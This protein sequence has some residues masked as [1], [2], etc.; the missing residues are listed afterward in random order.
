MSKK[1]LE[2]VYLH[3]WYYYPGSRLRR[4][5]FGPALILSG[6]IFEIILAIKGVSISP[7]SP[8]FNILL[9][10]LDFFL[11]LYGVYYVIWPFVSLMRL[12]RTGLKDSKTRLIFNDETLRFE[13]DSSHYQYKKGEIAGF[14]VSG[15][16]I[17]I[18]INRKYRPYFFMNLG[19]MEPGGEEFVSAL[20]NF[21][22][23]EGNKF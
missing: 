15:R 5:Y 8:A 1:E 6:I 11:I 17:I 16:Y 18:K 2:E 12:R 4:R 7:N 23:P 3:A 9:F 14:K 22:Q 20:C 10:Y 13:D 19:K 21:L